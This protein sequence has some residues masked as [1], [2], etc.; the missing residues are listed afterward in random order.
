MEKTKKEKLL[1]TYMNKS[2]RKKR[3]F[4]IQNKKQL[5]ELTKKYKTESLK[6]FKSIFSE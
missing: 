5:L 3:G 4:L 2:Y 1:E 6:Y